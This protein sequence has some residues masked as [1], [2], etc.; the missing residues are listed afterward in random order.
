MLNLRDQYSGHNMNE[1]TTP[2]TVIRRLL[3]GERAARPLFLP[4]IFSL[5]SRLENLP[6]GSFV[7]N[8]TKIV[9]ALR[10]VRSTL[11]LDGVTCYFDPLLEAEALGSNVE[12]TSEGARLLRP[13]CTRIDE[14]RSRWKDGEEFLNHGRI[15][16]AAEVLKRLRILLQDNAALAIA[17]TGPIKLATLLAGTSPQE[18]PPNETIEFSAE[19]TAA[20]SKHFVELG[21]DVIFLRET[22]PAADSG[23]WQWWQALLE[24]VINVVRFYEALPVLSLDEDVNAKQATILLDG[25]WECVICLTASLASELNSQVSARGLGVAL[26]TMLF[27]SPLFDDAEIAPFRRIM[28]NVKPVLVSTTMDLPP[29]ADLKQVG[30]LLGEFRQTLSSAV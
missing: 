20:V 27:A 10:Q 6:L 18:V 16:I 1:Q 23:M 25:T 4:M 28:E 14:V 2:R 24:P 29:S 15:P 9:S 13:V 3:Q 5:A 21:A 30:R 11:K 8:P 12:M 22:L 19:I 17:V 26:P 7:T